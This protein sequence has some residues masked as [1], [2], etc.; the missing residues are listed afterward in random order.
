MNMYV[1]IDAQ[2][3]YVGCKWVC[4]CALTYACDRLRALTMRLCAACVRVRRALFVT[5]SIDGTHT[6]TVF[7]YPMEL[8]P[9]G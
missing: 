7:V 4:V 2:S 9:R 6:Y 8:Y 5:P 3:G 1:Y